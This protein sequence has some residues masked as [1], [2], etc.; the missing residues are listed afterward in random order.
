MVAR[1][2]NGG[3][4]LEPSLADVAAG[5]RAEITRLEGIALGAAHGRVNR[6]IGGLDMSTRF[7]PSRLRKCPRDRN[8]LAGMYAEAHREELATRTPQIARLQRKLARIEGAASHAALR[9]REAA[10]AEAGVPLDEFECAHEWTFTGTA[11]GG[12]D[13]R[14]SGEGRCYCV[15]C[16]ADG[17]G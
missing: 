17:D 9:A 2:H 16:G 11:Y 6:K 15:H 12:D 7:A 13:E 8:L 10:A 1:N 14:W 3:P 4:S 5:L